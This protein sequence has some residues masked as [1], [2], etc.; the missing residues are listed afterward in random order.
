[1]EEISLN[2]SP[3]VILIEQRQDLPTLFAILLELILHCTQEC[4]SSANAARQRIQPHES[5]GFTFTAGARL[6]P[7]GRLCS[8]AHINI[9]MSDDP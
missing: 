2:L 7:A 1:V 9:L 4:L 3:A 8:S 5:S 6:R